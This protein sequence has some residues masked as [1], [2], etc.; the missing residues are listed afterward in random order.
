TEYRRGA[1]A[2]AEL[3]ESGCARR[4]P[5]RQPSGQPSGQPLATVSAVLRGRV[6]A[7]PRGRCGQAFVGVFPDPVPH[8]SPVSATVLP[9]PGGF[10]LSGVPAGTWY[11]L[12]HGVWEDSE[13][14]GVA[15]PDGPLGL[16]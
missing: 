13:A 6:N 10:V 11:V 7:L 12:A 3:P 2:A 1:P 9:Q 5:S 16:G 14:V 4:Q 15:A 8:G